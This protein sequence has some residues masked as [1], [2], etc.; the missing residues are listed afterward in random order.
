MT[1]A[2]KVGDVAMQEIAA[3]VKDLTCSMAPQP[4]PIDD[5][6]TSIGIL[7]QHVEFTPMQR[8]NISDF[9]MLNKNKN[10][11]TI[12]QKLDEALRKA[13]LSRRLSEIKITHQAQGC[14]IMS[15]NE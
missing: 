2:Q 4:L 5:L 11:T 1:M 12:F 15:I 6:S 3:V 10:H 9:L 8:L 7:N 13:W 14:D